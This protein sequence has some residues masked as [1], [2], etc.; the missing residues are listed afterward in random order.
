MKNLLPKFISEKYHEHQYTGNF[1]AYTMFIDLSGFTPLTESLMKEG[2]SGAE[3]LSE[4]LNNI[5]GPTVQMVYHYGGFIPYFAGDA[6]T[7]IFMAQSPNVVHNLLHTAQEITNLFG[8]NN[9]KFGDFV[10]GLKI[11]LSYGNVEWGN[12]GGKISILLL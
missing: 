9:F 3:K 12:Y 7:A 4:I 1:L 5:F 11:G 10:I 8:T 2:S 6:F